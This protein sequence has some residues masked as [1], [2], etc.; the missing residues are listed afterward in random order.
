MCV[1]TVKKF[2]KFQITN[3]G[4]SSL[5]SAAHICFNSVEISGQIDCFQDTCKQL[6]KISRISDTRLWNCSLR[7]AA[8]IFFLTL[9]DSQDKSACFRTSFQNV[10]A[11]GKPELPPLSPNLS[12]AVPA[13]RTSTSRV[14]RCSIIISVFCRVTSSDGRLG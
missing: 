14:L 10:T 12:R 8:H 2:P 1:R 13:P 6:S 4:N 5:Q 9:R 7:S 3:C 11:S